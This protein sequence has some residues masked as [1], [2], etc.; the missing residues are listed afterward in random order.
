MESTWNQPLAST[1]GCPYAN[2]W[3]NPRVYTCPSHSKQT[4]PFYKVSLTNETPA[5]HFVKSSVPF[6]CSLSSQQHLRKECHT[7]PGLFSSH[8]PPGTTNS[9]LFS[10]HWALFFRSSSHFIHF[11]IEMSVW[12]LASFSI[13]HSCH[14]FAQATAATP[15]SLLFLKGPKRSYPRP[16]H[17]L[18]CLECLSDRRP[19]ISLL[20]VLA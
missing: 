19:R 9:W 11:G 1:C 3:T 17:M 2:I 18:F 13:L 16:L 10:D 14:P 8:G 20:P 6:Q 7:S 12:A 4:F 15:T 5:S